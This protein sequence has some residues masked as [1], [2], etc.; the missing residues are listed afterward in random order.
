MDWQYLG[1]FVRLF[2]AIE[3]RE[4]A[5]ETPGGEA[6]QNL[7]GNNPVPGWEIPSRNPSYPGVKAAIIAKI[8][9]D[10]HSSQS[11]LL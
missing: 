5:R 8:G 1:G 3:E 10:G 2:R 11:P 6:E 7:R 9:G 4:W